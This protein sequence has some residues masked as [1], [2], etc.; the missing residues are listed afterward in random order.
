MYGVPPG[1]TDLTVLHHNR[2]LHNNNNNTETPPPTTTHT[3][4][5]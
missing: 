4:N 2:F 5:R 1:F 3:Q